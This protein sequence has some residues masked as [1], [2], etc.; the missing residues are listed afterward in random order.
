MKSENLT[1][2]GLPRTP[3][4]LLLCMPFLKCI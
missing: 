2:L 1:Y 4:P 3:N